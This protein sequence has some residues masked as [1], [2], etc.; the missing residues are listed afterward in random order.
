MTVNHS[1]QR[2]V[3]VLVLLAR[4]T[5]AWRIAADI[6]IGELSRGGVADWR[7]RQRRGDAAE[8]SGVDV[9]AIIFA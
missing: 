1:G 7:A 6:Q 8:L 2:A 4:A 9:A 5:G 3:A